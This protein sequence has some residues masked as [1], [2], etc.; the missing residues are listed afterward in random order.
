ME[1][2]DDDFDDDLLLDI[3]PLV[4]RQPRRAMHQCVRYTPHT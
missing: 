3:F 4:L 2:V 1:H